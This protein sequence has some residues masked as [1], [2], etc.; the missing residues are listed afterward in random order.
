MI[1][2]ASDVQKAKEA[3]KDSHKEQCFPI[4]KAQGIEVTRNNE[5]EVILYCQSL[6][7]MKNDHKFGGN[8]NDLK[9][10][11]VQICNDSVGILKIENFLEE[12]ATTDLFD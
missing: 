8:C 9:D 12:F 2:S 5:S 7:H 1:V 6:L 3:V 11:Q 10:T 4:F